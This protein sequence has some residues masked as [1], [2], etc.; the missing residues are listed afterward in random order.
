[1]VLLTDEEEKF[2]ESAFLAALRGFTT[3]TSFGHGKLAADAAAL[4]ADAALV[5]WRDRR[6]D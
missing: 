4:S 2:W 6:V 3:D 5:H 1:M